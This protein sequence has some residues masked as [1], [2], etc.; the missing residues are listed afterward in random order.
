MKK[1]L[2]MVAVL[3]G[4]LSLGACVD[5]DESASVEAV[6]MAKAKQLES[7]ANIN[8][9]DADAKKAI[10]A[11]EV[12]IKEA[13][14][15]YKK[16]QAELEQAQ[17]D[18]QKILLEKA[19]A[20]LEAELETAKIN[21]EAQLNYAKASLETAKAALIA[22]LDGVDQ[23][24]KTRITTLLG[25]ANGL[26][27]TIN[28]DRTDLIDAKNGL[29]RLKA[30]LVTVELSNQETIAKEEKNK[31]VAQ[32]LIAEY[33][34]Y[35]TKD[36]ADAEKA[37][38]EANAKLTALNQISNEKY[39]ANKNAIQA[40]NEA[41]TNLNGS[42][43]MQTIYRLTSNYYV[44]DFIEGEN[45]NYTNDDATTGSAYSRGY[46]K[47]T[48]NIDAINKEI[49]D[50]TRN[51]S[52]NKAALA[53]AN[54]ALTDAK[55]AGAYKN[56]TKAVTDAQKK[57]DDAKTEVDKNTAL[58]ELRIAEGNLRDYVKPLET[59]VE[60][61]TT[62]VTNSEENLKSWNDI[63]AGVSGDNATA[64]ATLITAMDNAVKAQLETQI[65]YNKASHNYSVQN[66]LAYTL[67]SIADG[68]ADY[69]QLILAQKQAIAAADE[70]IAN[71]ASIVS[72]EQAIANKE[73]EI[74][75]LENSLAVNEPIYND[76]L[77]QIKALVGDSAE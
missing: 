36:K 35:S 26:L 12:A 48:A 51:L 28:Q 49:T 60:S 64:Y 63:L 52:V 15:A 23:A 9:A 25:K 2:M 8:N 7:L 24:N 1:K 77:A 76:Y 29:A 34:K 22:A 11:A 37:A 50:Q 17:A 46:Y 4:A 54:K 75:D 53:D 3:L 33:E 6:R 73:K 59:A 44:Q 20:A 56:L 16:A 10:T 61:A 68:L 14:A 74:A 21:A 67:Q 71:A 38:Q 69:D 5:N 72:K 42:L 47:Y 66:S 58:N 40:F 41:N 62:G 55:A 32:A 30:E 65:A 45:V 57:F 70:N 18:Q 27:V 39:T 19:Q 13:E 43:Y 31:A